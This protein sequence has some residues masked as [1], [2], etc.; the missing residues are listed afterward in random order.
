LSSVKK[1]S[2]FIDRNICF[3]NQKQKYD[4]DVNELS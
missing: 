2:F 1:I 3:S 4:N